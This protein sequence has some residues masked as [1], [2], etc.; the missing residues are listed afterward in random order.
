[1]AMQ[2]DNGKWNPVVYSNGFVNMTDLVDGKCI[3]V[4]CDT[5]EMV[6]GKILRR[7]KWKEI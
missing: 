7:N 3:L 2:L 4:E 5:K 6:D 1:M